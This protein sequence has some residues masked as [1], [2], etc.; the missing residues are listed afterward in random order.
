MSTRQSSSS[1]A[2]LWCQ[3]VGDWFA[4]LLFPCMAL[5]LLPDGAV[6]EN[7][8]E[9]HLSARHQP[10]RGTRIH[11]SVFSPDKSNWCSWKEVGTAGAGKGMLLRDQGF[12]TLEN[13]S[14][15]AHPIGRHMGAKGKKKVWNN[16]EK[17]TPCACAMGY[18]IFDLLFLPARGLRGELNSSLQVGAGSG[19]KSGSSGASLNLGFALS[20]CEEMDLG[21]LFGLCLTSYFPN[22]DQA[23]F[24]QL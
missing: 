8:L 5:L 3:G 9:Q 24:E 21:A 2:G 11:S 22:Q 1:Q 7:S 4:I 17:V 13:L 6:W 10:L 16:L 12:W 18:S 15:L 14:H 23:H 20:V 19:N